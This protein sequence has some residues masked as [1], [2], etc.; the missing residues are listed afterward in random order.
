MEDVSSICP[1]LFCKKYDLNHSATHIFL[2]WN[3]AACFHLFIHFPPAS[4]HIIFTLLSSK[5]S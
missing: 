2:S 3:L 4:T 1:S 5:N